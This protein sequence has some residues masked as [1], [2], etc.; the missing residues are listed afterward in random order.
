MAFNWTSFLDSHHIYY[1][2]SGA[3][4][5]RGRIAVKCPFCGSADPSQ[6]MSISLKHGGYHCWRNDN[7]D[8][9][10]PKW[11]VRALI[12]CSVERA[13][14]IVG[15]AVFIPGDLL[16]AVHALIAPQQ[17]TVRK[18]IT[19]PEDFKRFDD[20]L[21][22]ARRFV[23]YL[24]SKDR[25]FTL[26]QIERF[27]RRYG[28]RYATS[29]KFKGR[30]IFPVK[31]EGKLMTYTGRTIYKD[32]ELRYKTLSYDPE[33]EEVPAVGPISDYLLFYDQLIDNKADCDTLI[34]CE[35]PF[36]ALKVNVIGRP[37]GIAATCFFTAS[38]SQ[39]Q[40][41]LAGDLVKVYKKRYLM[42]DQGTL[43]VALRTQIDMSTL[44]NRVL[45]LPKRY[46]DPGMLDEQGLLDIIP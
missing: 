42:L 6:H 28:L 17:T 22:S 32:V 45:T 21:P 29:G 4:V 7:H 41:D 36:D 3:N 20:G 44:I 1:A 13:Q 30:I 10:D 14:Q 33:L 15:E 31:F 8:G 16:G 46:K 11:L 24:R 38:P 5:S 2:T 18:P 9:K 37:H 27:T 25:G 26:K 34:Y 43:A 19:L 40:I 35:G 39:A 23:D 12:G